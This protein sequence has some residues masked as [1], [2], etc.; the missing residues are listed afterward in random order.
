[1]KTSE[2]MCECG[3]AVKEHQENGC[4]GKNDVYHCGCMIPSETVEELHSLRRANNGASK[5]LILLN[6][7]E[8]NIKSPLFK[9][10][11]ILKNA[12]KY[13]CEDE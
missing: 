12:T 2:I 8:L 11:E 7:M 5:A 1:M 4:W 10:Y 6:S 3:H 13:D 9:I